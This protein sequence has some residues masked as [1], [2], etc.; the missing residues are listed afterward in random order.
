M[1]KDTLSMG[2]IHTMSI[3]KAV[4]TLALALG[5]ALGVSSASAGTGNKCDALAVGKGQGAFIQPL[6]YEQDVFSFC[7]Y[8]YPQHC[9]ISV[10]PSQGT[11]QWIPNCYP[12]NAQW[13]PS[14]EE[15]CPQSKWNGRPM[16][17]TWQ[18][19]GTGLEY[20]GDP[21]SSNGLASCDHSD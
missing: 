6:P 16:E 3:A 11:W 21:K 5:A 17:G 12:Q 8:G 2:S 15:I 4:L 7:R 18:G 9:W 20:K 14:F 10:V 19:P 1:R 13:I